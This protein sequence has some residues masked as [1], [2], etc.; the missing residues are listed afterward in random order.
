[1]AGVAIGIPNR[2][3]RFPFLKAE[4]SVPSVLARRYLERFPEGEHRPEVLE[5]LRDFEQDR[6]NYVGALKLAREDPGFD[7]EDLDAL[8]EKAARQALEASLEERR[9]DVR[10]ELLREA[11]REFQGTEAGREAGVEARRELERAAAQNI[12]I[13]RG[14]LKENPVVAGPEGLALRPGLLDGDPSNGELHPD[15][16]TLLGGRW[17]ELAFVDESGRD[18]HDP[19]TLRRAVSEERLARVVAQLEES[20]LHMLLV[21]RDARVEHDAD[22]DRFFE[23]ARLGVVD[24]PDVRPLAESSY[25]FLGARERYGLVRGRE[26]ILPV[27][28]VLQGS[29]DDFGLGAFPRIR[30]PKPTPDVFLY[31]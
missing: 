22:R 23:R 29:F 8:R 20:S 9:R 10:H 14:F 6:G 7:P 1:M 11:A 18:G 4:W 26:S 25:T 24:R 16:V 2:L 17:I 19:V 15:G 28:I 31:R 27:E 5:W 13:S 21:D 30:M 12:R 3:I